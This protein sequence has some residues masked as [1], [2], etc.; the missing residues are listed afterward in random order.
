LAKATNERPSWL[1]DRNGLDGDVLLPPDDR[2]FADLLVKAAA[3]QN[4]E[5]DVI[6]LLNN[7]L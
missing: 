6:A 2:D 4:V 5:A 1:L 7:R 3:G